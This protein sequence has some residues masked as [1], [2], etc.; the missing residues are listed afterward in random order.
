MRT[1]LTTGVVRRV[2]RLSKSQASE[3]SAAADVRRRES[4]AAIIS[5]LLRQQD[6][7]DHMDYAVAADDVSGN[8]PALSIM[9]LLPSVIMLTSEPW[10]VFALSS[11]T[12]SF[13]MTLPGTTW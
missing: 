12:T 1:Q 3:I 7:I 8:H 4:L 6:R 2:A 9:T 13:D 5:R 11:F 10:T